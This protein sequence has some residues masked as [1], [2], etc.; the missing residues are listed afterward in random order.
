MGKDYPNKPWIRGACPICG[1]H[2]VSRPVPVNTSFTTTKHLG[3]PARLGTPAARL[4]EAGFQIMSVCR[5][6]RP[7]L[8]LVFYSMASELCILSIAILISCT[9]KIVWALYGIPGGPIQRY[10]CPFSWK[11]CCKDLR[12]L[13]I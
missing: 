4:G 3:S 13:S 6:W 1:I 5:S 10:N 8:V 12:P 2:E 7:L 9:C 11:D